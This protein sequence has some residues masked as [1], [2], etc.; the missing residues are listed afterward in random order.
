M[1]MQGARQQGDCIGLLLDLDQGSMIVWEND[2]KPGVMVAE[3]LSGSFCW[4]INQNR[5]TAG[6]PLFI[7]SDCVTNALFNYRGFTK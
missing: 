6:P 2:E 3:R 1:G 7:G 4:A 5:P